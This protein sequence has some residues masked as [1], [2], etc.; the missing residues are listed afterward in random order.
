MAAHYYREETGEGQHV[1]VSMQESVVPLAM[2]APFLWEFYKF[3]DS[4]EQRYD[5]TNN[6][7]LYYVIDDTTRNREYKVI[8]GSDTIKTKLDRPP[9][10][11]GGNAGIYREYFWGS[12]FTY[13]RSARKKKVSGTVVVAFTI[14]T[15]GITSNHRVIEGIGYGCDEVSLN[16]VKQLPDP[17][18][19]GI[20]DGEKVIVEF[21]FEV[22]FQLIRKSKN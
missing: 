14:D 5:Y 8:V 19:P 6:E 11:I 1:D 16:S 21:D 9:D 18:I 10:F 22:K 12:G 17:W 3:N 20:L 7:L 15:N 2:T 13:P 4:I